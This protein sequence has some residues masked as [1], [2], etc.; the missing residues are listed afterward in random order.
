MGQRHQMYVVIKDKEVYKP[1]GAWHHQWCFGMRATTNF[2]RMLDDLQAIV[3]DKDNLGEYYLRDHRSVNT[4][5]CKNYGTDADSVKP[6]IIHNETEKKYLIDF[7]RQVIT[8]EK[9]DNNDG[10]SLFVI[11]IQ[12]KEVRGCFFTPGHVEGSHYKSYKDGRMKAWTPKKYLSFYYNE[13]EMATK[14]FKK[15]FKKHLDII[16]GCEL[17]YNVSTRELK[18]I[19]TSSKELTL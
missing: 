4:L 18:K 19:C 1:V 8:P 16:G 14:E 3:D 15:Q 12:K 17:A 13:E 5:M 11:D 6:S 2:F 7:E 10:C 9:G